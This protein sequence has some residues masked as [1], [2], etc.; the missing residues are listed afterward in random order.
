MTTF[1]TPRISAGN[2]AFIAEI[3]LLTMTALA[4]AHNHCS[5]K[6]GS[7]R[8]REHRPALPVSRTITEGQFS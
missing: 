5:E 6:R 3:S 4:E 1:I 2:L 8:H 7:A